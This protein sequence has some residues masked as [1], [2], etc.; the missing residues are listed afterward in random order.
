MKGDAAVSRF[1]AGLR[2]RICIDM[3]RE[4][5]LVQTV[6]VTDVDVHTVATTFAADTRPHSLVSPA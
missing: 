1:T 4:A 2:V 3:E 6:G 5:D